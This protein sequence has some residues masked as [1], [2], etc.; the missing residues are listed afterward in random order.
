MKAWKWIALAAVTAI[1]IIL[2]WYLQQTPDLETVAVQ[3]IVN[4][5]QHT[6]HQFSSDRLSAAEATDF[7]TPTV[8]PDR[9]MAHVEALAYPRYEIDGR[10]QARE[11]LTKTLT[12]MGWTPDVQ[13]FALAANDPAA[14]PIQGVNI[15][16]QRPGT[17]PDAGTIVVGAHYDTVRNSP[18]ADDNGSGV[19]ATLEIAR[20]LSDFPTP[21][22]LKVVFFDL[23]EVGLLGSQAFA[24]EPA[25]IENVR[26]AI[27]LD[28]IGH[29]C[30]ASGCQTY[31]DALPKFLRRRDRGDFLAVIGGSDHAALL[32]SFGSRVDGVPVETLSIPLRGLLTPD[33][34]RSDHAPFWQH[35][36]PAVLVTDTANFRNPHYHRSTD[37]V[38]NVDRTFMAGSTQAILDATARSLAHHS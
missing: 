12:E 26:G 28:M 17:D 18:G 27:I 8:E 22:A 33:L 5:S 14:P 24:A 9:L 34:L 1:A 23:D 25:N 37:G 6:L 35:N 11:Y 13:A 19:A 30:Y 3:T 4:R 21:S 38:D 32:K 16:A 10:T 31:P 29:A 36:V 2:R 7:V 15:V 20:L